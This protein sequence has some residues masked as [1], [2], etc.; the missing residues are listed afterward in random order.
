M[1]VI[2]KRSQV[3]FIRGLGIVSNYA[4]KKLFVKT[5]NGLPILVRDIALV[6]FGNATRYGAATRDGKGEV[7]VGVV[8]MLKGQNAD[9]ATKRVKS[10]IAKIQKSLPRGD[11]F[12]AFLACSILVDRAIR[13]VN[14]TPDLKAINRDFLFWWLLLGNWQPGLIVSAS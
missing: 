4:L 7:V 13:T 6:Q 12:G 2:S 9:E 8:M 3:Y 11:G 5:I 10:Q 1:A 14:E